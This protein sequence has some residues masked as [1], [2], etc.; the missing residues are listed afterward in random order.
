MLDKVKKSFRDYLKRMEKENK[1]MF[2]DGKADCCALNRQDQA[3]T[4]EKK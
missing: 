2:G 1:K 4:P 3:Q